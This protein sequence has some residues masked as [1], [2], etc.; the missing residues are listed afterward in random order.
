MINYLNN[1]EV[2]NLSSRY[3][4]WVE[5]V[6]LL[7][8][9]IGT[10][11]A[12][13]RAF[14]RLKIRQ[15][16]KKISEVKYCCL[17]SNLTIETTRQIFE[18]VHGRLNWPDDNAH[19]TDGKNGDD[20]YK[21]REDDPDDN[22]LEQLFKELM[23]VPEDEE[24]YANNHDWDASSLGNSELNLAKSIIVNDPFYGKDPYKPQVVLLVVDCYGIYTQSLKKWLDNYCSNKS[25]CGIT[26]AMLDLQE[27]LRN[28]PDLDG[29][30]VL[31]SPEN[32]K[33]I[34]PMVANNRDRTVRE[35]LTIKLQPD[36][37]FLKMV[38]L[39]ELGH[40]VFKAPGRN[41]S[42]AMANWFAYCFLN[43]NEKVLLQEKTS[44][45]ERPYQMYLGLLSL[46]HGG[47]HSTIF[48]DIKLQWPLPA[49]AE[50]VGAFEQGAL[51]NGLGDDGLSDK[52][53]WTKVFDWM[54]AGNMIMDHLVYKGVFK[55]RKKPYDFKLH[56]TQ[57][58]GYLLVSE[59][60][61]SNKGDFMYGLK[62]YL[63]VLVHKSV[64]C[65]MSK[66]AQKEW[67][68]E[69]YRKTS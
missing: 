52:A 31:L 28:N 68:K 29:P 67:L 55:R 25:N 60:M 35:L 57:L 41:L 34:Q 11:D 7:T 5:D 46:L 24:M 65:R 27:K 43:C 17:V 4:G 47:S 13:K 37:Q 42:E 20:S 51:N 62:R 48:A 66:K 49:S 16:S 6:K 22:F 1:I 64:D 36:M 12:L 26:R 14:P 59:I 30:A 33:T 45:Q 44:S 69:Q 53:P 39:H 23:D 40:H 9:E 56:Y 54:N 3:C 10:K 32:I 38:F 8:A 21:R 61:G 18:P 63:R 19:E 50:I 2:L 58:Y 15:L